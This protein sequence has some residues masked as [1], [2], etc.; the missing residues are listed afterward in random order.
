MALTAPRGL[1]QGA[2]RSNL[3]THFLPFFGDY[4][5]ASLSPSL[6]QRW[7][8]HARAGGLSARSVVKYHVVLHG[9]LAR[10]V[11]DR[12]IAHNPAADTDLPKV[13][14]KRARII[15]PVEFER[16]LGQIPHHLRE[17]LVAILTG[18][19]VRIQ[20]DLGT[21]GIVGYLT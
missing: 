6:V 20:K 8:T 5:L 15:T 2:Y 10:A 19:P 9:I 21:P 4:P 17:P 13:I 16:L 11:R 12:V 3:D 7:V 14:T 18:K 1:H